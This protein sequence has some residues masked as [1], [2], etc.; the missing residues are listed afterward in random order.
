MD[1][2]RV[3]VI[4]DHDLTRIGLRAT[5]QQHDGIEVVGD[6]RDASSGLRLLESIQPDVAIVDI[7]LPDMTGIEL[8]QHFKAAQEPDAFS[9][10]KILIMTMQDSEETVLGAFAAG[11]DSYCTKDASA[12]HL[13]EAIRV[14]AEGYSWIEPAIAR[15]ILHHAQNASTVTTPMTEVGPTVAIG[16]L[17]DEDSQWLQ[18][19]PLTEREYDV[20]NLI[21]GGCSNAQIAEKLYITVG[22]V[23]THVRNILNKMAVD[24]RTQIAVRALR[25]GLVQ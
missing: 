2:I 4:E 9:A 18:N 19:T 14:T 8:T 20:L 21:V 5:L 25:A 10:T 17:S 1:T 16:G 11:A 3:A 23:K 24:D 7:G 13:V 22:T 12:A 15:I 6:A